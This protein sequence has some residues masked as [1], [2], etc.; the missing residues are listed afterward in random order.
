M[1]LLFTAS[2][3][4]GSLLDESEIG[5]LDRILTARVSM[6]TLLAGKMCYCSL[7]AFSQMV[8]MF[9]WR[10]AVFRVDLLYHVPGFLVM[11]AASFASLARTR[12]QLS[13]IS[14]LIILTMSAVGGSMFPP[15]IMPEMMR[16]IGKITFKSWA[17][18]GYSKV[19][20]RDQPVSQ[21]LPQ[22]AVE[23]L[24]RSGSA[25]SVWRN[26][27]YRVGLMASIEMCPRKRS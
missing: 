5:A 26:P 2:A 9:L 22:L 6:T 24:K 15:Y 7:L 4:G 8:V 14:T 13:S 27:E 11:T 17:I 3:A 25:I 19:F 23:S 16:K 10:A 12:A 20:W 1:F 21:L 18:E